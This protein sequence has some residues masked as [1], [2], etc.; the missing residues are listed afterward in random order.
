MAAKKNERFL[1]ED[2]KPLPVEE[3]DFVL[4][5]AGSETSLKY[6]WYLPSPGLPRTG[7]MST[8]TALEMILPGKCHH[9]A[10]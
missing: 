3:V 8:F 10:R 1:M 5:G 6:V 2:G 4:I 7:T 9:M